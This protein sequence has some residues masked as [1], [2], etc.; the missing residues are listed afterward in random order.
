M[1]KKPKGSNVNSAGNA[2]VA[3]K[4]KNSKVNLQISPEK[5][6]VFCDGRIAK[7]HKE[8]ANILELANDDV[9][10]YHANNDRNDFANWTKDVFN[11]PELADEIKNA[12]TRIDTVII[13]Y[14]HLLGKKIKHAAI[15]KTK[16][17][18]NSE[19][20]KN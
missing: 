1:V 16:L 15:K 11:N 8:L 3:K 17:D 6:F 2:D 19:L 18:A 7:D 12:K 20:N 9:F 13:L 14:K 10:S 5:Y 4:I